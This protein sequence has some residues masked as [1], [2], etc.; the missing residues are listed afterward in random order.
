MLQPI[1]LYVVIVLVSITIAVFVTGKRNSVVQKLIEVVSGAVMPA[2]CI[3]L[4]LGALDKNFL[5]EH[6]ASLRFVMFIAGITSF[7][8]YGR[9]LL[10][11]IGILKDK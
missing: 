2:G 5:F 8:I 3:F 4:I 10:E 1:Y 11:Q 6:Y 9:R 7:L